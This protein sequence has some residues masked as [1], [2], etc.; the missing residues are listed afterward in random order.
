MR[1]EE[2]RRG[3]ERIRNSEGERWVRREKER[4][5]NSEG[6]RWMRREEE[7]IRNSERSE[8]EEEVAG[9]LKIRK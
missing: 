7:R 9:E 1:R 4:I 2:E 6:E 3:E 8:Q 5:R